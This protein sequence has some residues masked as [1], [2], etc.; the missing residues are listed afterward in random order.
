M[1]RGRDGGPADVHCYT[2]AELERRAATLPAVRRVREH[3]VD[4]LGAAGALVREGLIACSGLQVW[5]RTNGSMNVSYGMT[6]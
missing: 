4:L 6:A 5:R 2:P 1:G 3:G